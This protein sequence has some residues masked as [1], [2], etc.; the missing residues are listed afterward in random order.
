MTS[1]R[2]ALPFTV[3]GEPGTLRLIAGEDLR[4]TFRLR[5]IESWGGALV[6]ALRQ[7]ISRQNALHIVPRSDRA[8]AEQL[9]TRLISERLVVDA[10]PAS[11]AQPYRVEI[12]GEGRLAAHLRG[13]VSDADGGPT[14]RVLVQDT[15]DF[16][17]V[18]VFQR[19][20]REE[21]DAWLW[22]TEAPH[23]R[24]FISHVVRADGGPCLGCLLAAF[25]R[26]SP[27]PELYDA[28]DAHGR[29]GGVL[30]A[31][32]FD[33]AARIVVAHLTSLKIAAAAGPDPSAA[34]F[35]LH[36]LERASLEV[37]VHPLAV[38]VDCT[39]HDW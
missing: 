14:M 39:E 28:L 8:Q 11:V 12:S 23:S 10:A 36:V 38:D 37:S 4:Y 13:A 3:I 24:A 17:A 22:V 29:N 1:L 18:R 30:H 35:S 33:D 20:A 9:L 5:G 25:R 26:L 2:L 16:A 31:L 15:L 6:E 34:A 32:G 7:P 27:S 19:R 21:C